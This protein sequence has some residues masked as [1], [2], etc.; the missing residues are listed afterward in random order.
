M[1]PTTAHIKIVKFGGAEKG[2]ALFRH[3]FFI[4]ACGSGSNKSLGQR[5]L[6]KK[7]GTAPTSQ[8]PVLIY[9]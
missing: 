6:P 1:L 9:R 3:H 2:A 7:Q 8:Q 5:I 4:A